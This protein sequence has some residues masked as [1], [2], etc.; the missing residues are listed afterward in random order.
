MSFP[1]SLATMV[2]NMIV[3]R[4][5]DNTWA[6]NQAFT[7]S[8]V[9]PT[10]NEEKKIGNTIEGIA[11]QTYPF[12]KDIYVLD[13][14]SS[15]NTAKE[16]ESLMEEYPYIKYLKSTTNRG[17][18]RN[19]EFLLNHEYEGLGDIVWV[20]D[21]DIK[22]HPK[23][24]IS[25]IDKFENDNVAAVSGRVWPEKPV[26]GTRTE[27]LLYHGRSRSYDVN[28]FHRRYQERRD[29]L[30]VLVGAN[31]AF[32]KDIVHKIGLPHRTVT[33]D[34]DLC[35]ILQ[36]K[37]YRVNVALEPRSKSSIPSTIND[38]YNQIKRWNTGSLQSLYANRKELAKA[39]KLALTTLL[40]AYAG[41]YGA[42]I[43][44]FSTPIVAIADPALGAGMFALD[45]AQS[46]L[47]TAIF[48]RENLFRYPAYY[49]HAYVTGASWLHAGYDV[50][51]DIM[52]GRTEQWGKQGWE[53]VLISQDNT[54]RNLARG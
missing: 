7:V 45:I 22:A 4:R 54:H 53:R 11:G 16:V 8:A 50:T 44:R 5:P 13:D 17:K 20:V 6:R 23:Q 10:Y 31:F 1:V 2:Y 28:A 19:L 9:I 15:D 25:L 21:S 52:M 35:W 43:Y 18:G 27:K 46:T 42:A 32:R 38:Y 39:P 29:A 26:N 24:L 12:L 33:E 47:F 41:A 48:S 49:A 40:P 30:Y 3:P 14:N 51:K 36:E 34:L 37:G